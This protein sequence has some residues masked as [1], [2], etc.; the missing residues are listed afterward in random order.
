MKL[1]LSLTLLLLI[2]LTACGAPQPAA[3]ATAPAA[4]PTT[5]PQVQ[6]TAV[7][8]IQPAPTTVPP[9]DTLA[10][11]ATEPAPTEPPPAP[12]DTLVPQPTDTATAAPAATQPR[13][14]PTSSGPLSA[15]IY[16]ANCRS[17][18]TADK[19]GRIIVQIS[20]EAS[21]GNGRYRYFYQNK[22]SP[23]K[24]IEVPGEKGTRLV[25]EVKVTS[26]DGQEITQE[27]DVAPGQLICP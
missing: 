20:V 13:P 19:P 9:T 21:G 4:A 12:T 7:P 16:V 27:F 8:P 26:G 15:A 23:T 6:P 24:F 18:P 10:P 25:G 2:A 1:R 11:A 14:T 17:A 22:E 5:A 3:P